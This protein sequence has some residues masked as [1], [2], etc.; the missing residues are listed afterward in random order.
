MAQG[1]REAVLS[2]GPRSKACPRGCPGP[3][4]SSPGQWP[5]YLWAGGPQGPGRRE[6]ERRESLCPHS[7]PPPPPTH[8]L[9]CSF[10]LLFTFL[11]PSLSSHRVPCASCKLM[12]GIRGQ[13]QALPLVSPSGVGEGTATIRPKVL[14]RRARPSPARLTLCWRPVLLPCETCQL[15]PS[16]TG[17]PPPP[18][19]PPEAKAEVSQTSGSQP[20]PCPHALCS[21]SGLLERSRQAPFQG[22][23]SAAPA[24]WAAPPP[25]A[26]CSPPPQA[27]LREASVANPGLQLPAPRF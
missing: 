5:I 9:V 14:G 8:S 19:P 1:A 6:R 22:L 24:A 4:A 17:R 20:T 12:L 16:S 27:V 15:S 3:A 10:I 13:T 2:L 26:S 7:R 25:S 11:P 21:A 23:C 18:A